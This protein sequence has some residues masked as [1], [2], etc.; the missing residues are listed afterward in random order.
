MLVKFAFERKKTLSILVSKGKIY[1]SICVS[2]CDATGDPVLIAGDCG[3]DPDSSNPVATA[4]RRGDVSHS[5]DVL[6]S[7]A[8][9]SPIMPS[10]CT[11][12]LGTGRSTEGYY[13][14]CKIILKDAGNIPLRAL[15]NLLCKLSM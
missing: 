12:V 6:F 13:S 10:G 3:G 7:P 5:D 15:I 2:A 1:F 4:A 11:E 9:C 8:R 14:V